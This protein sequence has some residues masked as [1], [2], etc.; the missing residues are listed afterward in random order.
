MSVH[1]A[2]LPPEGYE[3]DS[4]GIMAYKTKYAYKKEI[5]YDI[6]GYVNN[7]WLKTT[8]SDNGYKA[9]LSGSNVSLMDV[10]PEFINDGRYL[11]LR[12][13]V[14]AT[15][16]TNFN[17][18]VNADIM[19]GGDDH[20]TISRFSDNTGFKMENVH[21][22]TL[23]GGRGAQFNFYGR[24]A[25]GVSP[26]VSTYWFGYFG[27]RSSNLYNNTN[28]SVY[29]GNDSGMALSWQDQ[30]IEEGQTK[31][32]SV[33]I[34]IGEASSPPVIQEVQIPD[35][36]VE[37]GKDV[38]ITVP[39]QNTGSNKDSSKMTLYYQLEKLDGTPIADAQKIEDVKYEDVG[40]QITNFIAT[41]KIPEKMPTGEFN[42]KVFAINAEG[43]MSAQVT[44]KLEAVASPPS[45]QSISADQSI[46]WKQ[47]VTL[48][49]Q[50]MGT[51]DRSYQWQKLENGVYLNISGATG[52]N[53]TPDTGTIGT[54]SYRCVVSYVNDPSN[55]VTSGKVNV[56]V[57]KASSTTTLDPQVQSDPTKLKLKATVKSNQ[58]TVSSG[59]VKFYDGSTVLGTAE[60]AS[61]GTASIVI[62]TKDLATK[63]YQ[64]KATF[65]GNDTIYPSTSSTHSASIQLKQTITYT[66]EAL[67]NDTALLHSYLEGAVTLLKNPSITKAGFA[68][69]GWINEAGQV[70]DRIDSTIRGSITLTAQ[71]KNMKH[72]L[73]ID[74]SL[75]EQTKVVEKEAGQSYTITAEDKTD[76]GYDFNKWISPDGS[77]DVAAAQQ[78]GRAITFTMPEKD[79]HLK[80]VYTPKEY[81]ITYHNTETVG[82]NLNPKT[83]TYGSKF[84]LLDVI[85]DGKIFNGW[86]T[87]SS[88]TNKVTEIKSTDKADID[89]YAKWTDVKT[90]TI[91]NDIT[92]QTSN[93]EAGVG[94]TV[95]IPAVDMDG[96]TF[97]TWEITSGLTAS[98]LNL[99]NQTLNFTM[100]NQAV[101]I[102]AKYK[103]NTYK[104]TY[105]SDGSDVT[106]ENPDTYT[107][108][109]NL[110]L[111]VPV[112]TGYSF[113][114]WYSN[115]DFKTAVTAVKAEQ[116]GDITLYAKWKKNEHLLTATDAKI[117]YDDRETA[118]AI[119]PY[120]VSVKLVPEEKAG[121]EFTGWTTDGIAQ[122]D[123]KDN[124]FTM[125]DAAVSVKANYQK[126]RYSITYQNVGTSEIT[127]KSQFPE[128]Y[129][130]GY[131][132]TL[133]NPQR[134]GYTFAGWYTDESLSHPVTE[135]TATDIG[136][137]MFYAKW[138]ANAYTVSVTDGT[139]AESNLDN[140]SVKYGD[141][142]TLVPV[143]KA[144]MKFN[145]WLLN[146]ESITGDSFTMPAKNVVLQ[147]TYGRQGYAIS[148]N[149]N[150]GTQA[151]NNPISYNYGESK[152]FGYPTKDG[153]TFDGW[154]TADDKEIKGITPETTGNIAVTA[155]WTAKTYTVTYT[156]VEGA[157]NANILNGK[158]YSTAGQSQSIPLEVP[159]KLGFNFSKWN[160]TEGSNVVINGNSL[161]IPEGTN[162]NI[163]LSAVWSAKD[164]TYSDQATQKVTSFTN[165]TD[166]EVEAALTA[167]PKTGMRF[168]K[169][170]AE[171][172]DVRFTDASKAE[173]TWI[174]DADV[175]KAMDQGVALS[176]TAEYEPM[177]YAI[178]YENNA[179]DD[180]V[181]NNN[182]GSYTYSTDQA[183]IL[184]NPVREGYTFDGWSGVADNT[185]AAGQAGDMTLGAQWT[186][187]DYKVTVE[188]GT[189]DGKAEK[190]DAHVNAT[191]ALKAEDRSANGYR[192]TGW[193]LLEG[194]AVFD[195][196]GAADTTFKMTAGNVKVKAN[197][198][199][200]TYA[201]TYKDSAGNIIV[202]E[203]PNSIT[204][205]SEPVVLKDASRDGYT[206]AGWYSE[207]DCRNKV[208]Q[209][210]KGSITADTTLYA[211]FEEIK[212]AV[213][214][215]IRGQGTYTILHNGTLVES[216]DI[217][218]GVFTAGRYSMVQVNV[219]P[220]T[221]YEIKKVLLN[222]EEIDVDD[223]YRFDRLSSSN[224]LIYILEGKPTVIRPDAGGENTPEWKEWNGSTS[225]PETG[226]SHQGGYE[227]SVPVIDSDQTT[228]E[229][230]IVAKG[231]QPTE[232]G[233]LPLPNDKKIVMNEEGEYIVYISNKDSAGTRTITSSDV[234]RIDT[235]AP[236]ISGITDKDTIYTDKSFTVED[237]DSV[238]ITIDGKVTDTPVIK[239]NK[240]GSVTITV[241]DKAGNETTI[242]VTT[243]TL[244]HLL[245][246]ASDMT[247]GNVTIDAEDGKAISEA[248]ENLKALDMSD[249]S[250]DQKQYVSSKLQEL[251]EMQEYREN[252]IAVYD[253]MANANTLADLLSNK[254]V[255]DEL[256]KEAQELLD[257]GVFGSKSDAA[258]N[259][260][261]TV[262][263]P[264]QQ[265]LDVLADADELKDIHKNNVT[266]DHEQK[267][268]DALQHLDN[269]LKDDAVKDYLK[270]SDS[271]VTEDDLK[272]K[273]EDYEKLNEQLEDIR[274]K[275]DE[276]DTA[277]KHQDIQTATKSEELA[278][279]KQ[280]LDEILKD[281][282]DNLTDEQKKNMQNK[283]EDVK[284]AE[285]IIG[286][287][288]K[289][290]EEAEQALNG[291]T[292]DNIRNDDKSVLQKVEE[293][294]SYI[295]DHKNHLDDALNSTYDKTSELHGVLDKKLETM[296][297][298]WQAV[299]SA[300]PKGDVSDENYLQYE[301]YQKLL[302]SFLER[303]KGN[304]NDEEYRNMQTA[305]AKA[306]ESI[307][308]MKE[309]RKKH[310]NVKV[311]DTIVEITA[312]G[313]LEFEEGTQLQMEIVT[314]ALNK[315]YLRTLNT[316]LQKMLKG[317]E[318]KD[319]YNIN[320]THNGEKANFQGE[321]EVRIKLNE[322]Q[323]KYENIAVLYIADDSSV[324]ELP[325]TVK[326]G[327]VIFKTTHFSYYAIAA[328][329]N[330][331]HTKPAG[332]QD[333]DS[334]GNT[335][336]KEHKDTLAEGQ[337]ADTGD[338][339]NSTGWLSLLVCSGAVLLI[340]R[341][342]KAI[343][344]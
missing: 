220:A 295:D 323:L 89:L 175:A 32:Y 84:A 193:S 269:A 70:I 45:I 44:K 129:A 3:T 279:I 206:F 281:Y 157:D 217:H 87:D 186:A 261:D 236:S 298:D 222:G 36:P 325:C 62:D 169:W 106:N 116:M 107:F 108:G 328:K 79:A 235:T 125:P 324:T 331:P 21:S 30:H 209:L 257:K 86:Y 272:E 24:D 14:Y 282:G 334:L 330:T 78:N 85:Q 65:T 104:I 118:S 248:L 33:I 41:F 315:E 314:K 338:A 9:I 133:A 286:E 35:E 250:A 165:M 245:G 309:Y 37:A 219:S 95:N 204:V 228:V 103:A 8:Y 168:K 333:S 195:D 339:S 172:I 288:E 56:T 190:I 178:T 180:V 61:N 231:N 187:K 34:G 290:L 179:D 267:L 46:A 255:I 53:Y 152:T 247:I 66:D 19:I 264:K 319:V 1:A 144:G 253:K 278:D 192:F 40:N 167:A 312:L 48:S 109:E 203:N 265:I 71:W 197:Y 329:V 115:A 131:H 120:G 28:Y 143:E 202:S 249:A 29:S 113:A 223:S 162:G 259:L 258:Q 214:V 320:L 153:Y 101:E 194:D 15:M 234:I 268:E 138:E 273:K 47:P 240:E 183:V 191:I 39:V 26:N 128:S 246:N 50:T 207:Q 188:N 146:G 243:D 262:L 92:K 229:Y 294:L 74:S 88:L 27:D 64:L 154:Y 256:V 302:Q 341:K 335:D 210:E 163:T 308:Q 117:Q 181:I 105:V 59:S 198:A 42:L 150:E 293:N 215:E 94:S 137:K 196:A 17:L 12:Y 145:G 127:D 158:E 185:I 147:A 230:Q 13:K 156:N 239:G 99:T 266:T 177:T 340:N 225:V 216:A 31:E 233:W 149:L 155:H 336:M 58:Q 227:I 224:T 2:S 141:S 241:T 5:T 318:I 25:Y 124:T 7:Y 54:T 173:T 72:D 263:L 135:I 91:T 81:T 244:E 300:K 337:T 237:A 271:I 182:P 60:L 260:M 221:G 130:I 51:S 277:L 307:Q 18:S 218:D 251:Q 73:Y 161:T 280:K 301:T 292:E 136:N 274:Q 342:R 142:V 76:A 20:A 140:A 102:S 252:A 123:I 270:D 63:D 57:T 238:T 189:V 68:F 164:Y 343:Q 77:V 285:Q 98:E 310:L 80:A 305:E 327:Y 205:E 100:P 148:Y 275:L 121:Y 287:I 166:T 11:R 201:L 160:V 344:K 69:I 151:E 296:E 111:K 232:D 82:I 174:F 276:V 242:T 199:V 55:K 96:Y 97:E 213:K 122:S 211:K 132:K 311:Q 212:D 326:D 304:L 299:E 306:Q 283:H 254:K 303:Y 176:I 289:R 322:E 200:K 139:I 90:V 316:N 16:E 321:V 170:K 43:A 184:Q 38:T 134:E 93:V 83:Y 317:Y 110:V 49:C 159:V 126:Q 119:V 226:S 114:G 52:A 10:K 67:E 22:S 313:S 208:E 284:T 112:R 75:N 332:S 171:G 23:S 291:K 4:H 6:K 297:N